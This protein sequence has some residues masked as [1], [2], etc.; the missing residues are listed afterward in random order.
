MT[1][2]IHIHLTHDAEGPKHAPA[3]SS[4]GGQFTSG[5]GGGGGAAKPKHTPM[6][7]A[8]RNL[9]ASN[10]KQAR[11]TVKS[12]QLTQSKSVT[13]MQAESDVAEA[14]KRIQAKSG[15]GGKAPAHHAKGSQVYTSHK[16]SA[17]KGA[18]Q[19]QDP[20]QKTHLLVKVGNSLVGLPKSNVHAS[21][22][23][24]NKALGNS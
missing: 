6:K 14:K 18:V 8:N 17:Y 11:K 20:D 15:G 10:L 5:S 3:G 21:K 13:R 16:A 9:E 19:G 12:P 23:D 24:A 22:A 1:K 4:K 7:Q 2:H